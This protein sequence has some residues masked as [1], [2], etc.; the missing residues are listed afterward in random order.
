MMQQ[1][2]RQMAGGKLAKRLGRMGKMRK[3]FPF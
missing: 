2:T 1:L 3:G